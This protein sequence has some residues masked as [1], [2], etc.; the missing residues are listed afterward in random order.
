ML[1]KKSSVRDLLPASTCI[2]EAPMKTLS[3]TI[4]IILAAMALACFAVPPCARAQIGSPPDPGAES[5]Q[6]KLELTPAQKSAIYEEASKDKS[7][8]A[9]MRFPAVVGA[10]VPPMIQLYTLPDDMLATNPTAGFFKY[11]L[12]QDQVVL[13]DP[14]R[15]RVVDVIGPNTK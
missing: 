14:T 5:L 7:K 2:R 4:P 12:V 3:W 6:P 10:E 13:V 15:M 11:T 9:P 8:A 1:P